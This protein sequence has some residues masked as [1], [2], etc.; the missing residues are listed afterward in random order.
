MP[1][2]RVFFVNKCWRKLDPKGT[3][4][5][6]KFDAQ[7][8]FRFFLRVKIPTYFNLNLSAKKHPKVKSGERD[9]AE[10]FDKFC[11]VLEM[12][13]NTIRYSK[14]YEFF[15]ALSLTIERDNVFINLCQAMFGL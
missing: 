9:E 11:R 4:E 5:V 8:V 6:N 12:S 10:V 1:E 7:K 13:N 15:L 14:F 2:E 3:G